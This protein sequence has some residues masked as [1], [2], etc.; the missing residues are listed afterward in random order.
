MIPRLGACLLLASSLTAQAPG[1]AIRNGIVFPI[2]SPPIAGGVVLIS[3]SRI[4]K[5]GPEAEVPIPTGYEVIDARGGHV[6]PG[7]VELHNHTAASDLQDNLFQVNPEYRVLDNIDW[8]TPETRI[9][10]AGGVTCVLTIPGSG[11]N[12]TGIGVILKTYGDSPEEVLVRFPGALKI[13][14]AGNPERGTGDL[15]AGRMGMSWM[16][17]NVLEE[18]LWYHRAW[19][20]YEEGRRAAPPARDPRYEMLR[21]LYRGEYPTAVHTQIFQVVQATMRI[22]HDELKLRVV[23]AHGTFDG[24]I[25]APEF[26]KRGIPGA[27]GPRQ[28]WYDQD[29]SRFIGIAAAWRWLGMDE[30]LIGVN[31]DAPVCPEEELPFQAAMAVRNGLPEDVALAGLTLN[32][33]RMLQIEDRVG[34]LEPGKDADVAIWTGS[35]LDPRSR[36]LLVLVNGKVAYDPGRDGLRF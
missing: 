2:S 9:A 10:V 26:R 29:Q 31:T 24:F 27:F 5:V 19:T 32:V 1:R 14:Q 11:T 13:A 21:G 12:M 8:D 15:G 18:G 20:E 6:V 17:R 7:L 28:F 35:P 22:L 33:A 36:T 34:S 16:I 30:S 3:G 4:E 23:L 25:N